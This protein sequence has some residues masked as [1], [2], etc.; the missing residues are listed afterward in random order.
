MRSIA[1]KAV[2]ILMSLFSFAAFSDSV[3]NISAE[4]LLASDT[5]SWLILDVRTPEE[6]SQG[7]VPGAINVSHTEIANNLDM[8]LKYKNAP[9]VVYC[10]SG[11]RAG[12]AANVLVDNEFTQ[13]KH[14]EGDM[15]G[16]LE[17][18]RTI[19]K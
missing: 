18:G 16:W 4:S 12:K 9:V 15:L 10:R 14:L 17:A 1:I 6:Y 11:Y 2:T 13:V 19:E 3:E 5:S 7:H 8:L